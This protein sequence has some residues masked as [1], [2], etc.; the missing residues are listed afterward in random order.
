M[1]ECHAQFCEKLAQIMTAKALG[2]NFKA[3]ELA[4]EFYHELGKWEY[5]FEPYYDHCLACRV[6]EHKVGKPQK[7][8]ID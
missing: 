5:E 1:L 7:I 8:I 4:K 3:V 6:V 2:H